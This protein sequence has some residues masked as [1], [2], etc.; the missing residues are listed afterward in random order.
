MTAPE[1][2]S[3]AVASR[4][5][6]TVFHDV[7][8]SAGGKKKFWTSLSASEDHGIGNDVEFVLAIDLHDVCCPDRGGC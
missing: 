3:S 6:K 2:S 7:F 8:L 1:A 5:G 4:P